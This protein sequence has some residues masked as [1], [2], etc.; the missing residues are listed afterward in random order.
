MY[1][2]LQVDTQYEEAVLGRSMIVPL[3][4]CSYL[5]ESVPEDLSVSFSLFDHREQISVMKTAIKQSSHYSHTI[6]LIP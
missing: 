4:L 5:P 2:V 1:A 3:P 6:F